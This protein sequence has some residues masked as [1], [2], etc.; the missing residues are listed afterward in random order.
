MGS[1]VLFTGIVEHV[2]DILLDKVSKVLAS[3]ALA[4]NAVVNL[5]KV[6]KSQIPFISKFR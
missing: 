2:V 4:V 6:V 3:E 5:G 1:S